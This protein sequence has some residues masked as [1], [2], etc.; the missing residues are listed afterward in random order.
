MLIKKKET[1]LALQNN[2]VRMLSYPQRE[3]PNLFFRYLMGQPKVAS[4]LFAETFHT[5]EAGSIFEGI[6]GVHVCRG[7]Y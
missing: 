2:V 1:E 7:N 6:P 5:A 4:V 3:Q